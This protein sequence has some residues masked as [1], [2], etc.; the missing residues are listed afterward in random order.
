MRTQLNRIADFVLTHSGLVFLACILIFYGL[1]VPAFLSLESLG[2]I[3]K[4]SSFIGVAALG[5][6]LVLMTAG[7]DLSVGAVMFLAPLIAG[8]AMKQLGVPVPVGF[9]IAVLS[10][11]ML[12]AI[13]AFFIVKLR[14]VPFIVTLATMFVFRG[15]GIWLTSS[16]SFDFSD[17]MRRFGLSSVLGVP[18]PII[19]FA[20][21]AVLIYVLLNHTQ[22]GR[23]IY[24]L[25][26]D[27]EA[28]R[29]AGLRTGWIEAG[30][31]V[32]SSACAAISG[33]V[34]IAQIGRL[35]AGF[36]EGREFDVIAA[37]ILGGASFFG[38]VG[39]AF[40][41]VLGA[42]LIQTAKLGLVFVGVNLYLQPVVLGAIIFL[43]VFADA[44]RGRRLS[45]KLK[46]TIRPTSKG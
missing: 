3:V 12:G 37:A 23:Q 5:M 7:I 13:N 35:D 4:Q 38:G 14:V 24:A 25:G 21:M 45:D 41:A 17:D 29:K 15:F 32:I 6:T 16:T 10:G 28:A 2:N 43:A 20:C 19:I 27:R 26:N 42:I 1:Q 36:G 22:F 30:V 34:I 31:Y 18:T 9:T 33:F 11:A 8:I 44:V 40:G 46:R 39:T